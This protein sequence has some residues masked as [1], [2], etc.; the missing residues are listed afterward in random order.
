MAFSTTGS[1]ERVLLVSERLADSELA[2]SRGGI[3]F[4]RF[5]KKAHQPQ[6]FETPEEFPRGYISWRMGATVR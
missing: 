4:H 1:S 5:H 6:A 3:Y 2:S